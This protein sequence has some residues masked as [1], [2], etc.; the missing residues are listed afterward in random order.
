MYSNHAQLAKI[1]NARRS[2]TEFKQPRYFASSVPLAVI[3]C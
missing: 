2:S 3:A 1:D